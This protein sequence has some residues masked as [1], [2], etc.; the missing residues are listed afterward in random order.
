MRLPTS[1]GNAYIA[2]TSFADTPTGAKHLIPA[3]FDCK[4]SMGD[5]PPAE[6]N[7]PGQSHPGCFI[8]GPLP[9][10][11]NTLTFEHLNPA[12]YNP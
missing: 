11:G 1:R 3:N 9:F 7:V 10:L 12:N 6:S 2:G 4:P 8:Q 5:T